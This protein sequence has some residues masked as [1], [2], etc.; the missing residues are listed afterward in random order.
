MIFNFERDT[1]ADREITALHHHVPHSDAGG[2]QIT[3][4]TT[5]VCRLLKELT[6]EDHPCGLI[7]ADSHSAYFLRKV[8]TACTLT[9]VIVIFVSMTPASCY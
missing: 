4:R 7:T 6:R 8:S 1:E 5:Q 2:L 3:L 9:L